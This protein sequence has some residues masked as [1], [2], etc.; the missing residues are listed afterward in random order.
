[1]PATDDVLVPVRVRDIPALALVAGQAMGRRPFGVMLAW[2]LALVGWPFW[3][4][5]LTMQYRHLWHV[6]HRS[7][8]A[9]RPPGV[10]HWP[11][12]GAVLL[13]PGLL[14][15][16][17]GISWT[18]ARPLFWTLMTGVVAGLVVSG[19]PYSGRLR[20]GPQHQHPSP[21]V[22]VS[23]A[24]S[25]RRGSGLLD[26]ASTLISAR[27]PGAPLDLTARDVELLELYALRFGVYQVRPGKGR[28]IGHVS[29]R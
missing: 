10:R 12:I 19:G 16:L 8:I 25:I 27:F 28:M 22:V 7:V 24:A 14:G 2:L 15:A 26:K 3:S 9:V 5:M 13:G 1:M 11:G 6:R 20:A 18:S 23:M 4:A 29:P 21:P 17:I